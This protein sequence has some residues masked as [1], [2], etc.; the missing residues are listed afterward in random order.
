MV[1]V[2]HGYF[3]E[4]DTVNRVRSDSQITQYVQKWIIHILKL[5]M[6][7]GKT[8]LVQFTNSELCCTNL[9]VGQGRDCLKLNIL[10]ATLLNYTEIFCDK[11]PHLN[12]LEGWSKCGH[13][14]IPRTCIN[15]IE[16][17]KKK[18][19]INY[20]LDDDDVFH[21]HTKWKTKYFAEKKKF[22]NWCKPN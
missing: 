18:A 5:G 19:Y 15:Y 12:T 16:W 4:S 1:L 9:L 17:K 7:R 13:I 21:N 22:G 14:Q 2:F 11:T 8:S 10:R 20:T 3:G 6:G